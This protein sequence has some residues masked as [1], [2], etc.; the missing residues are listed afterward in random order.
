M[1]DYLAVQS[2]LNTFR[3]FLRWSTSRFN[4]AGLFFGHG[5]EDAFNEASQL[6]LS[7]LHLPVDT[8]PDVFLDARLTQDEKRTLLIAIE[9]RIEKRIPLPYLTNEAWF[10]GLPFFVDE[11]VLI[12]RSPFAELIETQF[13]PWVAAPDSITR[14]IDMCTG[15]GC[16]AIALAMA[17]EQAEVTASDI[18]SDALDV[19]RVNR[20]KYGLEDELTLLESDIWQK[21][22]TDEKYDL[23]IS[24]PPYVGAEEMASLPEEYRHEPNSAL[25]AD[26]SGLALVTKI[27]SGAADHLTENG[28]IFIE[29]GNTDLAVDDKWPEIAF[30][31]LELEN[32]GHGIFMLDKDQCEL[33]KQLYG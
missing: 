24:N 16:I 20:Q 9:K 25:E 1:I 21:I 2:E 11:R 14:I 23:I 6:L 33:F 26:D 13:Q 4:E 28:L 5:N 8:L 10:A 22:S 18:S 27:L 7:S 31:W 15:S 29:V 32:G 12:P 3:D 19:A 30:T 17:F